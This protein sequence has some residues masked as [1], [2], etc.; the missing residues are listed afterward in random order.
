M[1]QTK[2]FKAHIDLKP[3]AR[4]RYRQP[5]RLSKFDE[6]RLQFLYEEAEAEGKV[7]QYGLGETPPAFATPLI[8]VGKKGSVIGRKVGDVRELNQVTFEYHYPAPEADVVLTEACGKDMHS[9]LDCAWGFEQIDTDESTSELC[10]IVTSFG[11]FKSK[12]LPQGIKQGP[13]IYQ[14]LQDDAFENEY[15]PNGEKLA[16]VFF[17]DT[18]AGDN[19]PEEHVATLRR[20]LTVARKYNIQYRREKC[21]FF[22]RSAFYL[23]YPW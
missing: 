6:T 22:P 10:S 12:T 13:A 18:H 8:V 11:V 2:G 1:P 21:T 4:L 23:L 7:E 9:V 15:K 19:T 5:Y 17:D 16:R 14:H 20:M 3:G